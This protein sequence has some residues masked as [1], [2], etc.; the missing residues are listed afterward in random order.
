VHLAAGA[1]L[2]EGAFAQ[3]WATGEVLSLEQAADL[4]LAALADLA[5]AEAVHSA[6]ST[7]GDATHQA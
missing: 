3:V 1:A 4:A 7:F 5:D 6:A 2:G